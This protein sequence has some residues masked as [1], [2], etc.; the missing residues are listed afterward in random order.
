MH[1][2]LILCFVI[3]NRNITTSL[4]VWHGM[5]RIDDIKLCNVMLRNVL[6]DNN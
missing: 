3:F 2:A 6:Y 5:W 4:T 1:S